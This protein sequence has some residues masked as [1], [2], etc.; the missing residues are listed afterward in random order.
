MK[1]LDTERLIL[2]T[3]EAED[4]SFYLELV[5]DPS[6][7][8]N[9]GDKGIRTVDAAREAI[10]NGPCA[11][12]RERGHSLYMVVRREDGAPMGLCGLIKRDSLPD[13]DI[14]YALRPAYWGKGY[15]WE[16]AAAVVAYARD[17]VGLPR[18]LGIT[19]PANTGSNYLLQKLGLSFVEFTH[20]P[21]DNRGTNLYRLEF[22]A[23]II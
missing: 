1:I 8:E 16:A 11:M 4:A 5:N 7:L 2:R 23:R 21:P 17:V 19:D 22:P 6:W 20:L 10:L 3:L 14:G 18:L 15:A 12:Q 13:V 9:I